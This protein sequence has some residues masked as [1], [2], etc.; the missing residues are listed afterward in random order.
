MVSS[1][2]KKVTVVVLAACYADEDVKLSHMVPVVPDEWVRFIN[3]QD[4][5]TAFVE[6]REPANTGDSI[7]LAIEADEYDKLN[8]DKD[9]DLKVISPLGKYRCGVKA[10]GKGDG[11]KP[12]AS[13][14]LSFVEEGDYEL[15]FII[16]PSNPITKD[17][18]LRLGITWEGERQELNL[19]GKEFVGGDNSNYLWSKDIFAGEHRAS[20][21]VPCK[22]GTGRLDVDFI[23]EGIVLERILVK[24]AKSNIL[25]N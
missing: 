18:T 12:D 17:N 14:L 1:G 6:V 24:N 10:L 23:D 4:F 25:Q 13:Y 16:A 20:V 15:T 21:T 19:I 8:D 3:P 7:G 11:S 5:P 9:R 22:V 2:N